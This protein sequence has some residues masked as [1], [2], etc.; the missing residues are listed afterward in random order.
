MY[1]YRSVWPFSPPR[2]ALLLVAET[3]E[4]PAS[5]MLSSLGL[6]RIITA[7]V[8]TYGFQTWATVTNETA[9]ALGRCR[10]K[11]T[12]FRTSRNETSVE[13]LP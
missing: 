8:S 5:M 1:E 9:L 10:I 12:P 7:N 3:G 13:D 11:T 6:S 2:D 4:A